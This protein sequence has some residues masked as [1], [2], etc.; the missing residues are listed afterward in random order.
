MQKPSRA[1]SP[2]RSMWLAFSIVTSTVLVWLTFHAI[3]RNPQLEPDDYRYLHQVQLLNQDFSR[4]FLTASTVENHWDHLW[5]VNLNEKVRFFRPTVVLSYWADASFYG[6]NLEGGLLMTNGVIY[7]GCVLL[8]CLIFYRWMGPGPGLAVASA[9]FASFYAHGEVMWYVAGRTDSLAALFMLAGLLIHLASRGRALRWLG[10]PC[11]VL[12]AFTKEVTLV[13]PLIVFLND[14]WVEKRPVRSL[15]R[16]E[17]MLYGAYVVAGG[18]I[19]WIRAVMTAGSHYPFPY[20]VTPG[21]P[22][23]PAHVWGQLK[24]YSSNL[25]FAVESVPFENPEQLRAHSGPAGI[26]LVAG[27]LALSSAL[28]WREK[29]YWI[30]LLVAVFTWIPTSIVYNSERYMFLPTFAVAGMACLLVSRPEGRLTRYSAI[31]AILLW[32]GHQAYSLARKNEILS[33]VPRQPQVM[34]RQLAASPVPHGNRILLLN[35]PGDWL[36][37]Q[38]ARDQLSVQLHD[39]SLDAT[40]LT[41]MPATSDMAAGIV[42]QKL[43][44]STLLVSTPAQSSL[45]VRGNDP[46]PWH[47]LATGQRPGGS[48]IRVEISQGTETSCQII[49]VTL[50]H[51]LREYSLLRWDP[52]PR[53]AFNYYYRQLH[54]HLTVSTL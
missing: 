10:I 26:L 25:L 4:N 31:A 24:S 39:P 49:K 29:K 12:A 17:G 46:L 6:E 1:G 54:S 19:L 28:L 35:L 16:S 34:G 32:T 18:A 22:D 48:D 2:S 51:P 27:M 13:L 3:L 41:I 9:L 7:L 30:F 37:A 52:D 11:F 40:V 44:D 45:M 5:W 53:K 43:D 8:A 23:F 47:N 20:F 38:F 15:I 21:S 36:E 50:P 42:E 33:V 14:A